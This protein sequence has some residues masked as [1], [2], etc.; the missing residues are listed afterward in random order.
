M[1]P[2]Y[3]VFLLLLLQGAFAQRSLTYVFRAD[4]EYVLI[5]LP[6]PAGCGYGNK[7]FGAGRYESH[8]EYRRDRVA[9]F[10]TRLPAG[11]HAFT[12]PLEP[13]FRGMYQQNPARA[14]MMYLPVFNGNDRVQEVGIE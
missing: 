9:I 13:R 7:V 12:V 11:E 3:T 14:E 1:R 6:T 10:C 5:E 2:R 8:R 4:A